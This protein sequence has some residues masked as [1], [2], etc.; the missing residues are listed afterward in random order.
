MRLGN[1]LTRVEGPDGLRWQPVTPQVGQVG[2]V[3]GGILVTQHRE[4]K[5][6]A[7]GVSQQSCDVLQSSKLEFGSPSAVV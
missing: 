5:L 6:A 4:H 1:V 2:V 7:E 3:E